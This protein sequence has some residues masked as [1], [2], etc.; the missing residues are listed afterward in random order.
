M[1]QVQDQPAINTVQADFGR[2]SGPWGPMAVT[3]TVTTLLFVA[4]GFLFGTVQGDI[5]WPATPS[6]EAI[7]YTARYLSWGGVA[8]AFVGAIAVTVISK[9]RSMTRRLGW[10]WGFLT[11]VICGLLGAIAFFSAYTIGQEHYLAAFTQ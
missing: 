8:L 1:S 11:F 3:V 4:S 5:P 6:E 10:E 2:I 9:V 7:Y